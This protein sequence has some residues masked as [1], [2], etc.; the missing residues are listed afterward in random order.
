MSDKPLDKLV[1]ELEASAGLDWNNSRSRLYL[2]AVISQY[3]NAAKK[4]EEDLRIEREVNRRVMQVLGG[5]CVP[6]CS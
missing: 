1:N 3:K 6:N 5:N 2:A 4:A